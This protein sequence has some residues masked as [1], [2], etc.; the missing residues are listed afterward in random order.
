MGYLSYFP[1]VLKPERSRLRFRWRRSAQRGSARASQVVPKKQN[2]AHECSCTPPP[3]GMVGKPSKFK[4]TP[5]PMPHARV[6]VCAAS[7]RNRHKN[8][9]QF[10]RV[11]RMRTARVRL[12]EARD[13]GDGAWHLKQQSDDFAG[14]DA[15][16]RRWRARGAC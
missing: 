13:G 15:G 10:G 6:H 11:A 1:K 7:A 14:D 16:Q 2:R 12:H 5:M 4:A 8:T 9:S 3:D